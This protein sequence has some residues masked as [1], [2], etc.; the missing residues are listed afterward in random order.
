MAKATNF[1]EWYNDAIDQA[2]LVDKRYPVKGMNVWTPYGLRVMRTMDGHMREEMAATGHQE[3][4]FPTLVP[5]DLFRKEEEHIKGFGGSVYWVTQGGSEPLD[6]KL[7]L[8]PTSEAAM[9]DMFRLWIRSHADLP[10]KLFQIVS[11]FRYETKQTRTFLRVREIHFFEGHTAHATYEEAEGQIAENLGIMERLGRRWC[12][13]FIIHRRPEWDKFPGAYYSLAA[14]TFI[15][16][17]DRALQVATIHEYRDNFAKAYNITYEDEKGEHRFVHQTT[18]GMSERLLGAIIAV[19]G[20]D[21]G[22]VLPPEVSPIQAVI[23]PIPAK[24]KQ[25][26]VAVA[27]RALAA[28]LGGQVRIHLDERDLR[29]GA[30]FF[31]WERKG[32]PLR[33]ELGTKDMAK[34]VVTAVR[35]DDGAK[36][37]LPK[38]GLT[39]QV[40]GL[41]KAI[42]GDLQAKAAK[43]LASAIH[44]LKELDGAGK[45]GILRMAWCG[46]EEC[47]RRIE[48]RLDLSVLGIPYPREVHRGSCIACGEPSE[49][50]V[51]AAKSY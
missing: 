46:K 17:A 42:H 6:V 35:R 15:A 44:V 27:A 50:W 14:D 16:P 25:Q 3:V 2:D 33:L 19:H 49:H 26:E 43:E 41:L 11:T 21:K 47:G 48:A 24:G 13:P 40:Q 28:D 30:K 29:P 9:Y 38:K 1:S 31:E 32:V 45:E 22:I 23:I 20:D 39:T 37:A 8:R 36:T 34:G 5:E 51:D 18:Y 7:A 10:L 12:L 4:Q